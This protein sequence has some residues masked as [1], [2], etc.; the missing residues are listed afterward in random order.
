MKKLLFAA[1]MVCIAIASYAQPCALWPRYDQ[2]VF[3]TADILLNVTYGANI[4]Y[5]GNNQVL[6][7]DIY[8]PG[9]DT[10]SARPLIIFAHGGSF[11]AGDKSNGD[12]VN[13]CMAFAKRGYVTATFNYR[14]GIAMPI[15]ASTATDAVYRAVQDMKAAIRFFR[16]DAA[17]TNAY[18]I[19][20][21]MIF[22]GGTSAGGFTALQT[23]YMD[24]YAELPSTI[25]TSVLGDLEGN[26]GN[27]GYS[28]DV[29][30][31]IN[32]CG[33]L[34]D[35]SWIVPNDPP[36]CSMHGTADNVVPYG[37]QM[38][39]LLGFVPIMVVD[40]S[41]AIHS[42]LNTISFPHRM[43]TWAGAGHV[44]YDGSTPAAQAYLDTT[45]RFVSNFLY[46]YLGCIP[47]DTNPSPNTTYGITSISEEGLEGMNVIN[48]ANDMI[49]LKNVRSPGLITLFDLSGRKVHEERIIGGQSEVKIASGFLPDGLYIIQNEGVNGVERKR[50][51]IR[52]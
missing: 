36:L 33:A 15:G 14:L 7:M 9:G 49:I 23:A 2:P 52:H 50:V 12:Q 37:S 34:G 47:T 25:D 19:D 5:Q 4:D 43:Y 22:I 30:A 35:A 38:L 44:P 20:P 31:V 41:F 21:N 1:G 16:Q 17:T 51:I 27:P 6:K 24:T 29:N 48:P 28:T 32:L 40:G 26:T 13:L 11:I 18:K 45:V 3:S 39:Y 46:D 42:Y 8:Q 10:L